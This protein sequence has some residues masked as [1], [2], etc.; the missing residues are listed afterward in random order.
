M[1]V[2]TED[3]L[4]VVEHIARYCWAVD[5]GDGDKWVA[6]WTEDGVFTGITPEPLVG[7][8]ALRQ[9]PPGIHAQYEGTICHL[10]GNITCEYA[11]DH[12]TVYAHLYNYVSTWVPG[13]GGQHQAMAKCRMTLVRNGAG[14][15]LRRNEAQLFSG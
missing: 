12:D 3:Y 6:V 11:D 2:S 1:P 4:G 10:A 7:H 8:D 15:L 14:W 9:V 5:S 13:Q